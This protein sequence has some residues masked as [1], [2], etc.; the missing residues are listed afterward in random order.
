M[1]RPNPQKGA[2]GNVNWPKT[3]FEIVRDVRVYRF[4]SIA[5]I[6]S[7][8]L[9]FTGEITLIRYLILAGNTSECA[10]NRFFPLY[11]EYLASFG[12]F[13]GISGPKEVP[14]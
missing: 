9:S 4:D 10:K 7:A 2:R 12:T 14:N 6:A 8:G 1:N 3:G 13:A 5:V 11:R